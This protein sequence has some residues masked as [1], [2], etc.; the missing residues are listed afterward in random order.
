MGLALGPGGGLYETDRASQGQAANFN[1][2][3]SQRGDL[4]PYGKGLWEPGF[5]AFSPGA[6]AAPESA[7]AGQVGAALVV[8]GMARL[9][10]RRRGAPD[11]S[12]VAAE[13]EA[14]ALLAEA[15]NERAR[16]IF[17]GRSPAAGMLMQADPYAFGRSDGAGETAVRIR[18][19]RGA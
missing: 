4:V 5:L 1:G 10:R 16:S 18:A 11:R 8:L 6:S 19:S 14:C 12:R 15:A 3:G 13:R 2:S 9:A 7:A 17:K